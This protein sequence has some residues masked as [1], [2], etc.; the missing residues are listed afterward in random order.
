MH[1]SIK[2]ALTLAALALAF[3][4]A[5]ACGGRDQNTGGGGGG[6][7][8]GGGA[9]GGGGSTTDGGDDGGMCPTVTVSNAVNNLSQYSGGCVVVSGAVVIAASTPYVGSSGCVGN[10]L[11]ETFYIQDPSGGPGLGVYKSCKDDVPTVNVADLVTVSGRLAKFDSSLQI[12][13]SAKYMIL[14]SISV[15]APDAGHA[16]SGAYPP[17][18]MPIE[19]AGTNGEYNHDA[20]NP[21]PEQIGQALH[22]SNVTMTNRYPPGF[23]ASKSDGGTPTPEGFELSNGVWVN[24]SIIYY[25]CIKGLPA[26][27]GIPLPN[28]I[29][30]VWDRYNDFYGGTYDPD[31]GTY[32]DA[33]TVPVL[34][35]M[36][37]ADI[38]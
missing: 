8:G 36:T 1:H 14:E 16:T 31:S 6:T 5:P 10:M 34:T 21:H 28:G 27:A 15:T 25:D 3:A 30:G 20:G 35:P 23:V 4:F 19:I 13:S 18:G 29:R 11:V 26:D 9:G 17:A 12:S 24:D 33:P 2:L 32:T 38:Q 37:C 22:F 7:G